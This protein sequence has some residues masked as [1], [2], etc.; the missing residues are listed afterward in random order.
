MVIINIVLVVDC[1]PTNVFSEILIKRGVTKRNNVMQRPDR[2]LSFLV[3]CVRG[4]YIVTFNKT[5]LNVELWDL[6]LQPCLVLHHPTIFTYQLQRWF[7]GC[8]F[9]S[10]LLKPNPI[11]LT[12]CS[13]LYHITL[14]KNKVNYFFKSSVISAIFR[15]FQQIFKASEFLYKRLWNRV[16]N[17]N[18][19]FLDR[20][21]ISSA[22]FNLKL[23][24]QIP[25]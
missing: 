10:N 13:T 12:L 25:R 1:K 18:Y 9:F 6:A 14:F 24:F 20:I 3:A 11:L 8:Y 16:Q 17:L 15:L 21:L 2:H 22:I 5:E 4:Q 19:T 7:P 23:L